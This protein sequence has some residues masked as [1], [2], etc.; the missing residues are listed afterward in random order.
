M[1][2]YKTIY[3]DPPWL[4]VG[5]GKIKRGADR[6]YPLM[7]TEDI[8]NLEIQKYI[9][10][11]AHLYLWVTNNFLEKGLEIMKAWGFEYITN[12][13]WSKPSFGLGYYFRG[14]HELC[15][16][17]IKGRALRKPK[18]KVPELNRW[19][20]TKQ[21]AG[22]KTPSTLILAPKNKHSTK[23]DEMRTLIETVSYEPYL[24]LFARNKTEGWDVWGNE[25][26]SDVKL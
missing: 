9:D 4:E 10:D 6:H 20:G 8:K 23:P 3:A 25:V 24:E 19:S 2:K 5:G 26:E 15:L 12:I 11:D 1:K 16:F 14:Q 21:V 17:G 22:V 13:S 7:K 18:H